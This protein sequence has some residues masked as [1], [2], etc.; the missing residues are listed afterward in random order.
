MI[1]GIIINTLDEALHKHIVEAL[2]IDERFIYIRT[3][4]TI[5]TIIYYVPVEIL[6]TISEVACN[7]QDINKF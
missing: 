6:I 1:F 4:R 3:C 2:R 5:F 7:Y